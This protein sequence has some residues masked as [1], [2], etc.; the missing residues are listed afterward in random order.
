MIGC[1]V[2]GIV[3]GFFGGGAY[4]RLVGRLAKGRSDAHTVAS[5]ATIRA[6]GGISVL[7][8]TLGYALVFVFLAHD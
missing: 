3:V 2:A 8:F 5:S 6:F 1:V 7:V 4:G